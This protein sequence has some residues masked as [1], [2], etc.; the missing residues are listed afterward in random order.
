MDK[1]ICKI[2]SVCLYFSMLYLFI[3]LSIYQ[4]F[5]LSLLSIIY[6][7]YSH[8]GLNLDQST[9]LDGLELPLEIKSEELVEHQEQLN[10]QVHFQGRIKWRGVKGTLSGVSG[11]DIDR[12]GAERVRQGVPRRRC[13]AGVLRESCVS[14]N[15]SVAAYVLHISS[16]CLFIVL[17]LAFSI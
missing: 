11:G 9:T 5:W 1:V 4:S 3:Y 14:S 13:Q 2:A 8:D 15:G 12:G 10:Q 17:I 6:R 7:K 16:A